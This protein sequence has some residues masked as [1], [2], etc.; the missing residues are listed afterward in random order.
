MRALISALAR[1]SPAA[2]GRGA[3]A[4]ASL[5]Q[6]VFFVEVD[7]SLCVVDLAASTVRPV[8]GPEEARRWR[9]R[10]PPAAMALSL[11]GAVRAF[12]ARVGVLIERAA[13][14]RTVLLPS[15]ERS[16]LRLVALAPGGDELTAIAPQGE[17]PW[18]A[19]FDASSGARRFKASARVAAASRCGRLVAAAIERRY[20]EAALQVFE[21]GRLV[22]EA[23]RRR[24]PSL[25]V[26]SA[27]AG[28][29]W[30]YDSD[31]D[32]F[33]L[34]IERSTITPLGHPHRGVVSLLPQAQG[35]GVWVETREPRG[36]GPDQ[37]STHFH[38]VEAPTGQ[39]A[40]ASHPRPMGVTTVARPV[41]ADGR[42]AL[43]TSY[44]VF[45]LD[46][47]TMA[48]CKSPGS[49][50]QALAALPDGSL[51]CAAHGGELVL[52]GG[53]SLSV[54]R[55]IACG[56]DALAV[57]FSGDGSRVF[58]LDERGVV[59]AF[60]L[61]GERVL[62]LP[63]EGPP[64]SD[65]S[66]PWFSFSSCGRWLLLSACP[67]SFLIDLTSR[68]VT[69]LD[70]VGRFVEGAGPILV[71]RCERS[72]AIEVQR[73]DP[74]S[75]APVGEV[76]RHREPVS[77]T[78]D[79]CIERLMISASGR[80]VL[81]RT[82]EWNR[83]FVVDRATSEVV[84]APFNVEQASWAQ[85]VGDTWV[86]VIDSP[87][88]GL[89]IQPFALAP[90]G[91]AGETASLVAIERVSA[92]LFA[93]GAALVGDERGAVARYQLSLRAGRAGP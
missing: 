60:D 28:A 88:D 85:L 65:L 16:W 31:G 25:L 6:R 4:A 83:G 24:C 2:P 11:D 67:R 26:F 30:G 35:R 20:N 37:P 70:G 13:E 33:C 3:L 72:G 73:F 55:R 21:R 63:L 1:L 44:E 19:V 50:V 7:G 59:Q 8:D 93:P 68:K 32:L 47:A 75:G 52:L 57:A 17:A 62:R 46:L 74:A 90:G 43:T 27:D 29:L 42:V 89:S 34:D 15:D 82:A 18:L 14:G 66:E 81:G 10:H 87:H 54:K 77:D 53:D 40:D 91:E 41:S 45:A 71:A 36:R 86:A 23:T 58:S 49:P 84:K 9:S 78:D 22:A 69:P 38:R 39:P 76:E 5:P 56:A 80:F 61:A 92:L 48:S 12:E 64:F 51:V 79:D